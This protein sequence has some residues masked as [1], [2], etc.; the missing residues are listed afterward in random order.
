MADDTK[1]PVESEQPEPEGGPAE[2]SRSFLEERSTTLRKKS[3][4]PAPRD[5][6]E[7]APE[8]PG[9]T[10]KPS[11]ADQPQ[12]VKDRAIT[13]A[14]MTESSHVEPAPTPSNRRTLIDQYRKRQKRHSSHRPAAE[15]RGVQPAPP[16]APPANNWISDRSISF[17]PGSGWRAAGHQRQD[18]SHCGCSRW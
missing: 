2:R 3:E 15:M 12:P 1:K 10:R 14:P 11:P 16:V 8:T 17:A 7:I 9:E 6:A 5:H 18:T 13:D 4:P